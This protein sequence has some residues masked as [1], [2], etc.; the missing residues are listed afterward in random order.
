MGGPCLPAHPLPLPY[1]C[2]RR[3]EEFEKNQGFSLLPTSSLTL[4]V[5]ASRILG[6][7]IILFYSF[8]AAYFYLL[9]RCCLWDLFF[10]SFLLF[11]Y[12]WGLASS[13]Y[14]FFSPFPGKY[15]TLTVGVLFWNLAHHH[16]QQQEHQLS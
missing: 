12:F 16:Y 13:C 2:V 3:K 6:I 8:S 10:S 14:I 4:I 15:P 7:I 9:N 11:F 1:I 5:F